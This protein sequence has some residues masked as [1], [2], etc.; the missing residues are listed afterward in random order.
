MTIAVDPGDLRRGFSAAPMSRAQIAAVAVTV[1]L[2][3]LDG[4]DVLS[5]TF[6]AP[7]IARDWGVG[8]AALGGLLSAGLAGMALGSLVLAPFADIVG[9]RTLVLASLML[10]AAGMLL[11]AF[12]VSLSQLV[13][14]RVLTGLGIGAMV[15]VINPL[16]AEFANTRRRALAL[17][18]MAMG[19]P[20]GG[21]VGG[22]A[23]ALL[24]RFYGWPAVFLAGVAAAV[25][26][27]PVVLLFL[28]EPLAFLLARRRGDSLAR[29][30]AL[31]VRC[32]RDRV[33]ILPPETI[34]ADA[35]YAAVFAPRQVGTTIRVTLANFLFVMAV[36]YVLSWLPQMV[37]EAGFPPSTASLVAAA[38]N[39][40]GIAG[41][42][43][44][45]WLARR[46]GLNRLTVATMIGLGL[47]TTVFG[48]TPA[49]L[50]LL[51]L[52]AG[53]CGFFLFGGIAGL[54]ATFAVS[55]AAEARASGS[56]F[57]IGI[58]RIGSAAAPLL[59]GW[60]FASGLGQGAVS[61]A[62]GACAVFAGLI[63]LLHEWT[64]DGHVA[65]AEPAA[66]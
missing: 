33:T 12:A 4:Y 45:G 49:S 62:F 20:L 24:L 51:V 9:R 6:A 1:A 14:W 58:G 55:F 34:K 41:G 46:A 31:L 13:A 48:L 26:L 65:N 50:P 16:A 11:S 59:A 29:V 37:A 36:Y 15:A 28:P 5:V 7:A 63:L 53:I 17:A 52:A 27:I 42:V 8:K 10:M 30:N 66:T 25:L 32:G 39:L 23:S 22:L 64:L 43:M 38:A 61:A 54:Y 47:A 35:G 19:Y 56:G 60:L 2:S 21:L 18:L 40:A 44:L 57:V 3:A